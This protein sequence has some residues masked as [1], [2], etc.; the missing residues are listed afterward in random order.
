MAL[1]PAKE[2]GPTTTTETNAIDSAVSEATFKI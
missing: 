1:F 2:K